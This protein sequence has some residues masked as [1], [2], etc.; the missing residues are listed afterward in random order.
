MIKSGYITIFNL[1]LIIN[2]IRGQSDAFSD[3]INIPEV[4]ITNSKSGFLSNDNADSIFIERKFNNSVADF[5]CRNSDCYIRTSAPGLSGTLS[6]NG[7]NSNQTKV[8]W[9]DFD[10][11]NTMLGLT[12]LSVV[13]LN[14]YSNINLT[15]NVFKTGAL[16]GYVNIST[17]FNPLKSEYNFEITANSID[18]FLFNSYLHNSLGRWSNSLNIGGGR[19]YNNYKYRDKNDVK[20]I[21]NANSHNAYFDYNMYFAGKFSTNSIL[22]NAGYSNREI[23][24]S[25]YESYSD[26]I[27]SDLNCKL[28]YKYELEKNKFIFKFRTGIFYN[29]LK[30]DNTKINDHSDSDL[31]RNET[32][33]YF[34]SDINKYFS[35]SLEFIY[36]IDHIESDIY[37]VDLEGTLESNIRFNLTFNPF[38]ITGGLNTVLNNGIFYYDNPYITLFREIY[39]FKFGLSAGK[40]LRLPS[41]ND[42]YWNKNIDVNLT[43]EKSKYL[44]L[45]LNSNKLKKI[46]FNLTGYIKE[47][48]NQIMWL[49]ESGIWKAQNI[50]SVLSSGFDVSTFIYFQS[51]NNYKYHFQQ[52]YKYNYSRLNDEEKGFLNTRIIYFPAHIISF[53]QIIEKKNFRTFLSEKYIDRVFTIYD[54]SDFIDAYFLFDFRIERIYNFEN[55]TVTLYYKLDNIFDY[56]YET[57]KNYPMP[58]RTFQ[59]GIA[60]NYK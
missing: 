44:E 18:N 23:P 1:L 33:L 27:Q 60:V 37:N 21:Q 7:S 47:I 39:G 4:L 40:N 19:N 45:K 6:L 31:F 43:V 59:L 12:D 53:K 5:L 35:P 32:G 50:K 36:K 11:S 56:Q 46:S 52:T 22:L 9:N 17:I 29:N 58:G 41:F 38:E 13:S 34:N 24:A 26:A 49:P 8:L 57:I 3:T 28:A 42:R 54:N 15:G 51:N 2:I 16:G 55:Y 10:I 48:T 14:R 25:I 30:Y 20:Y